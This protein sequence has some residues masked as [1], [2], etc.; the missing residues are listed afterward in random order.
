MLIAVSAFTV[1]WVLLVG[2]TLE[3]G[4]NARF[5]AMVHP[6]LV[7]V[8]IGPV[9]AVI[10]KRNAPVTDPAD[11]PEVSAASAEVDAAESGGHVDQVGAT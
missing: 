1:V 8:A 3:M 7:L 4:E 10:K 6:V 5:R 2:A 11:T 9:L